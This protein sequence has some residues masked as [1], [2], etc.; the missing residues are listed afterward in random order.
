MAPAAWWLPPQLGHLWSRHLGLVSSA[1]LP[2]P[3]SGTLA[4]GQG[5]PYF[6][7]CFD[8]LAV[9]R[10]GFSEGKSQALE[11]AFLRHEA[12]LLCFEKNLGPILNLPPASSDGLE[13]EP[14]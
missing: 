9:D 14:C 2:S 4:W 8:T 10:S 1:L 13:F 7:G 6:P 12:G 5:W 3:T 11:D